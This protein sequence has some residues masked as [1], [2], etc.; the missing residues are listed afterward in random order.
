M[1][2]QLA[3]APTAGERARAELLADPHRTDR[4]ATALSVA[5]TSV[6]LRHPELDALALHDE[7][8]DEFRRV[9]RAWT[10]DRPESEHPRAIAAG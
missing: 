1:Q 5:V 4:V 2:S 3:P 8:T 7:I 6:L 10:A 9:A